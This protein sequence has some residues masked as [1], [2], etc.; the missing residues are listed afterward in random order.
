MLA[1]L[2]AENSNAGDTLALVDLS[3][4]YGP[5]LKQVLW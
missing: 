5:A 4:M 1:V 2:G 3:N